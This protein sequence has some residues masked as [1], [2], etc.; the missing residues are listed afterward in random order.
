MH[1]IAEDAI[2]KQETYV[3][4]D[5]RTPG[6]GRLIAEQKGIGHQT[7]LEMAIHEAVERE[8]R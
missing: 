6:K 1:T 4:S 7:W 3:T 2:A 5:P 8:T